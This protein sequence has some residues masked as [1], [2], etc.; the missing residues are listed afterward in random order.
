VLQPFVVK[1]LGKTVYQDMRRIEE[2]FRNSNVDR[3]ARQFVNGLSAECT[4][5]REIS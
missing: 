1:L 3:N 4:R 2:L 5:R